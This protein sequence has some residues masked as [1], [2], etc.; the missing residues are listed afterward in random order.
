MP[1]LAY[2]V[3]A[4]CGAAV[5]GHRPLAGHVARRKGFADPGFMFGST[6]FLGYPIFNALSLPAAKEY[7]PAGGAQ[8]LLGHALYS[9]VGTLVTLVTVGLVVASYYGEGA[10]FSWRNLLAVPRAAPSIALVIGLLFYDDD[11]PSALTGLTKLMSDTTPFLM[12]LYL[13]M[14]V[15]WGG[16]FLP[17]GGPCWPRSSSS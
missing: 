14:S 10:G 13:G 1:L 16:M 2:G 4:V 9:E 3:I 5:L 6:A 17:T 15:A 11:L 7:A 12:M 8:A